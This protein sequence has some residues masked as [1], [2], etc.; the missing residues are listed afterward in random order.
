LTTSRLILTYSMESTLNEMLPHSHHE[1]RGWK[2][3]RMTT[4]PLKNYPMQH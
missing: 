3:T 1:Y 2:D 4:G